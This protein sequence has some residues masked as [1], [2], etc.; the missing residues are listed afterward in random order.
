MIGM[1][2]FWMVDI[3]STSKHCPNGLQVNSYNINLLLH[4]THTVIIANRTEVGNKQQH[5]LAA[6]HELLLRSVTVL[7]NTYFIRLF[8]NAN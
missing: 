5:W 8:C 1:K 4:S 3:V 2:Y 7:R 6:F